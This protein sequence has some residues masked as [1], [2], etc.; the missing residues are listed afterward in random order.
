MIKRLL[1]KLL[2]HDWD[3]WRLMIESSM[4]NEIHQRDCKRCDSY[5]IAL[6]DTDGDRT[7]EGPYHD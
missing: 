2:K 6:I 3:H 1:C 5:E 7:V 4:G